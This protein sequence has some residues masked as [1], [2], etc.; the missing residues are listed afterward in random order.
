MP[1]VVD[2]SIHPEFDGSDHVPIKLELNLE[3]A[4]TKKGTKSKKMVVSDPV[5]SK[6]SEVRSEPQK[7][8]GN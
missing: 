6:D 3:N 7:K 4:Q 2:S 1:L 8:T 5:K